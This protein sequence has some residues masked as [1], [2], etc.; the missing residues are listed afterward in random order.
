MGYLPQGRLQFIRAC[1][2]EICVPCIYAPLESWSS[3]M[4]S[5]FYLAVRQ[6][7][8]AAITLISVSIRMNSSY[9]IHTTSRR[10]S[11]HLGRAQ[12]KHEY[13]S[14]KTTAWHT[15]KSLLYQETQWWHN[16]T[17][18]INKNHMAVQTYTDHAT[19]HCIYPSRTSTSMCDTCTF[20]TTSPA[21]L[22]CD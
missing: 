20:L 13:S 22:A 19:S 3:H 16:V 21:S 12:G 14:A 7:H 1:P 18:S 4:A 5:I 17:Q 2:S 10:S 11:N 9:S 15:G 6:W 8:D